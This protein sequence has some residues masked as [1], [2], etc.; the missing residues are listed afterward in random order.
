MWRCKRHDAQPNSK[1]H[2][3]NNMN[4]KSYKGREDKIH[5]RYNKI[6]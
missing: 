3:R 5:L 4:P 1:P 6:T 2:G